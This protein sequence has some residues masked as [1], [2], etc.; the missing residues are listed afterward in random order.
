MIPCRKKWQPT[1]VL[2]LRKSYWQRSLVSYIQSTG[3]QSWTWPSTCTHM[4][5]RA[6]THTHTHTQWPRCLTS[7]ATRKIQIKILMKYHFI[8]TRICVCVC[9]CA[10]VCMCTRGMF[11]HVWLC[12]PTEWLE[13][14]SQKTDVVKDVEKL[15]D[16]YAVGVW[17]RGCKMVRPLWKTTWQLLKQLNTE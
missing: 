11:S 5:T 8:P 7:L 3:S 4:P 6:H 1:P 12:D 16:S 13:T 2:L 10:S 17:R 15:E 14:K 9:V